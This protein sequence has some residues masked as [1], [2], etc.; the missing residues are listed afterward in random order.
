M[1]TAERAG[2]GV[3]DR[4]EHAINAVIAMICGNACFAMFYACD[5]GF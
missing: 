5:Y 4:D 3:S 2:S 1:M